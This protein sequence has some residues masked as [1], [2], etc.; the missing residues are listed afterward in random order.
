MRLPAV[1]APPAPGREGPK[2][3]QRGREGSGRPVA[4]ARKRAGTPTTSVS[5]SAAWTATPPPGP[6]PAAG[7]SCL[8]T[9]SGITLRQLGLRVQVSAGYISRVL[10][11][12]R[13]PAWDLTEKIALTLGADIDALRKVW[14]DERDRHGYPPTPP[15]PTTRDRRT[16]RRHLPR[17]SSAYSP[18]TRGQS[19]RTQRRRRRRAPPQRR[20]GT[21]HSPRRT[22]RQL[23]RGQCSHPCSG[24]RAVV[25]PAAPARG[26]RLMVTASASDRGNPHQ[27]PKPATKRL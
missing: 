17:R 19:P 12:E 3:A 18:S 6:R 4:S 26:S 16:R 23:G 25:L 8:E 13:F 1:P 10:S 2:A 22:A 21:P 11:G 14:Q 15:A 24:R 27:P 5:C 7:R 9:A 20:R